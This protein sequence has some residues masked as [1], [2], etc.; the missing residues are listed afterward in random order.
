M[1]LIIWIVFSLSFLVINVCLLVPS[2][3]RGMSWEEAALG[4]IPGA[5]VSLICFA[6]LLAGVGAKDGSRSR[7]R[8]LWTAALLWSLLIGGFVVYATTSSYE[9]NMSFARSEGTSGYGRNSETS[10]YE[11]YARYDQIGTMYGWATL[12]FAGVSLVGLV[13]SLIISFAL[14]KNP[15]DNASVP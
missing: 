6:L 2:G 11:K 9:R 5:L 1:R 15:Q 4:I 10:L 8:R 3:S 14:R 12:G 7:A 13:G